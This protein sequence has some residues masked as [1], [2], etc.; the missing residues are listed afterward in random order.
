MIIVIVTIIDSIRTDS[1]VINDN[2]SGTVTHRYSWS[3]S[4]YKNTT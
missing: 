4:T 3:K 1:A 2:K